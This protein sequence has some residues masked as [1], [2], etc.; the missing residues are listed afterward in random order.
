MLVMLAGLLMIASQP[1]A[2]PPVPIA[3]GFLFKTLELDGERYAYTV[4]VP[5]DYTPERVW[6]C[7]HFLHGSGE[8]GSDGFKQTEVGIGRALRLDH[9]RIPA[10]V[11]MP[12]CRSGQS[13]TGAMARLAVRCVEQ[14]SQDYRL[15]RE[16]LYLT[17][18]S[19][20]GHGTW[21]L[22]ASHPRVFAAIVPV[23][24]FAE[25]GD[26]TGLDRRLAEQL[27]EIPTWVFHG[28]ADRNVPVQ[29]SRD[30]VALL[31]AGGGEV[32]YTVYEDGA[33]AIWDRV[34]SDAALWTWLFEQR[35]PVPAVEP[36]KG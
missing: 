27:V 21:L 4:F 32:Q 28:R 2:A 36:A 30:M 26:S 12:Q 15:D 13:W 17:G 34:Y 8:R 23:C 33:H 16:R 29:K 9:R 20:G 18:L 10:L 24:G 6:P 3:T 1:T 35:R 25:L 11:V 7:I 14:T 31:R 22:A 19:L 5:P